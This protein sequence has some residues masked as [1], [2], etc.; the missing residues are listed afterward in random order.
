MDIW[1]G[2]ENIVSLLPGNIYW[3]DKEGYFR[4]CNENHAKVLGLASPQDIIGLTLKDLLPEQAGLIEATENLVLETAL[5]TTIEE[6][7]KNGTIYLSKKA[8][9]KDPAGKVIGLIVT[10]FDITERKN[11]EF[12]LKQERDTSR[13][14]VDNILDN[15][16]GNIFWL[17]REGVILGANKLQA[18]TV[19]YS[20]PED[21]VGKTVFDLM[22]LEAAEKLNEINQHVITTGELINVEDTIKNSNG[23]YSY[24]QSQKVPMRDHQGNIVGVL[25]VAFDITSKKQA[26]NIQ[27][28]RKVSEEKVEAMKL[29]AATIAHELRT[30]LASISALATSIE[31]FLPH[32]VEA[33]DLADHHRL[34]ITNIN[35]DQ[36]KALRDLP[37]DFIQIINSANTFINMLLAKVNLEQAKPGNFTTFSMATCVDKALKQY[38]FNIGGKEMIRWDNT[39]DFLFRGD[40][41]LST[42]VIFNLLKNA[43][44]YVTAAG[45]GEILIWLECDEE[46]NKLHFKDTGKG[47]PPEV[48]ERIFEQFYS[49]THHGTGIGLAFC[50]MV[51]ATYNGKIS[52]ESVE[53]EFTHFILS[54]PVI[55]LNYEN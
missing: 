49:N 47:I 9:L 51:M 36:I 22:P 19:G 2:I 54:F 8:P 38:P 7:G 11:E 20:S 41:N 29:L 35:P 13:L 30:P 15:I 43:I 23:S 26:E 53:G 6:P 17:N 55:S 32:L 52:C 50:K 1:L 27:H 33:Y 39:N 28:E 25:G 37:A 4:G 24:F 12:K 5:E 45:K 40:E 21:I 44:Y 3:K 34:P 14:I 46:F 16:Q 10:S 42:Y 31:Y 48:L 18:Q